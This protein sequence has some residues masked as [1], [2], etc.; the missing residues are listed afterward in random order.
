MPSGLAPT[1]ACSGGR[2]TFFFS[3][4]RKSVLLWVERSAC[5]AFRSVVLLA[6]TPGN[7]PLC[8]QDR[9][10][11]VCCLWQWMRCAHALG[12]ILL[13]ILPWSPT[14]GRHQVTAGPVDE[15]GASRFAMPALLTG[16]SLIVGTAQ[17]SSRSASFPTHLRMEGTPAPPDHRLLIRSPGWPTLC[18]VRATCSPIRR[19]AASARFLLQHDDLRLPP[20]PRSPRRR[21]SRCADSVLATSR[22]RVS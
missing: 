11:S 22:D 6:T 1:A 2:L 8:A 3:L 10:R 18:H 7:G 20:F 14:D 16:V 4:Y 21:D 13:A 17:P 19:P 9:V 15:P 12:H 5:H